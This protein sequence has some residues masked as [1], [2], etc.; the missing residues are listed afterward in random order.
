[1]CSRRE[2]SKHYFSWSGGPSAVSIKCTPRHDVKLVFLHLMGSEGQVVYSVRL[3]RTTSMHY[4]S[5]INWIGIDST[6]SAS[7]HVMSNFCFCIR[8]DMIC[9][10]RSAFRCVR[11]TKRRNNIFRGRVRPT[12]FPQ[13][14][15]WDTLRR[16]CVFVSGGTCG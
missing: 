2:T 10:S 14:V 8:W 12:R 6:K 15:H 16:T 11:G 7:G 9:G 5:C 4:F 3:S 1:V 13:Q